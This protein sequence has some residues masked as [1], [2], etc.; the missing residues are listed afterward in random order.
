MKNVIWKAY[1]L[2]D[3]FELTSSGTIALKNYTL[4]DDYNEKR[5]EVVTSSKD[6]NNQ[7]LD[8]DDLP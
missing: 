5:V 1:K 8:L 3:L 6:N 7:F 4:F 2:G